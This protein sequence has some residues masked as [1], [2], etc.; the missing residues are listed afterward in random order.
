[1][2][3]AVTPVGGF[4]R[5]AIHARL[6]N[7]NKFNVMGDQGAAFWAGINTL[8]IRANN[9]VHIEL[10]VRHRQCTALAAPKGSAAARRIPEER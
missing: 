1:M 2:G 7:L 4:S 5:P 3:R 6:R 9:S 8:K 10:K